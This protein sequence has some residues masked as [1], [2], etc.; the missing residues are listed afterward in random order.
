MYVHVHVYR[1]N[2]PS[3]RCYTANS[4]KMKTSR[5]LLYLYCHSDTY[6][7]GEVVR[8]SKVRQIFASRACRTSIM[9]GKSL[10]RVEMKKVRLL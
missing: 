9:I 8:P 10:N 6:T 4:S 1:L 2:I 3:Y 5:N 7:Q